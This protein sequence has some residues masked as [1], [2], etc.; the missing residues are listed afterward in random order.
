MVTPFDPKEIR[1][2]AWVHNFEWAIRSYFKGAHI[3]GHLK[4]ELFFHS[5]S[6]QQR[7][8]IGCSKIG[9]TYEEM[10]E[11]FISVFEVSMYETFEE[12]FSLWMREGKTVASFASFRFKGLLPQDSDVSWNI[13]QYVFLKKLPIEAWTLLV[14]EFSKRKRVSQTCLRSEIKHTS[15]P[16]STRAT[17][18]PGPR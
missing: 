10:K 4:R 8:A 15:M 3:S 5:L 12:L 14:K 16:S 17:S 9:G 1:S 18:A 6:N 13:V 2:D 7:N 11:A